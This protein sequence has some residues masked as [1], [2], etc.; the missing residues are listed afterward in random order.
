MELCKG[1]REEKTRQ[2]K[3]RLG[4]RLGGDQ[5]KRSEKE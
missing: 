1:R 3:R 4:L 5:K 2:D